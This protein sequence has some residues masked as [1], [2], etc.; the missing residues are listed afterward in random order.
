MQV[1]SFLEEDSKTYSHILYDEQSKLC[2]IFDPVL[3]FDAASGRTHTTSADKLVEFIKTHALSLS[4]IIETHAHADHLSSAPYIKSQLG[5]QIVIGEKIT[6]VQHTFKKVFNFDA[7]FK[8]DASQFD[9][10]TTDGQMLPLGGLSIKAVHVPGHTP[11]DM[12]YIV[13]KNDAATAANLDTADIAIF[14]GDTLFAS[15]VGTAR[16]DFPGGDAAMLYDS[17]Q[18]L[19]AQPDHARLYLCHDYPPTDSTGK[20]VRDYMPFTTVLAQK[21]HNKH[22]KQ[23]ISKEDFIAMR[24][25]RDATLAMPRYIIPSVQVNVNA[26]YLPEPEANGIRYLKVPLNAL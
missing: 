8:T 6:T 15:D 7:S 3:D 23:G 11:A 4:Y 10:L 9:I 25:A 22:I 13:Q 14:V 12:A 24:T 17:I 26:G 20:P 1:V 16:C 21:Q 2:A 18:T 5:G 19:L